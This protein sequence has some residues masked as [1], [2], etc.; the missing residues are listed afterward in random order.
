MMFPC[1]RNCVKVFTILLFFPG[2]VFTVYGDTEAVGDLTELGLES[3]MEIEITTVAK[4]PQPLS[5]AAA[6]IHVI[7]REEIRRSGATSI[8][9][10]LRLAPG[11]QVARVNGSAWA[12]SARGFNNIIADKL[13]VLIDGRTIYNPI[14]SGV[15]WGQQE[16]VL[17]DID[18]IEVIRGPG[19]TLWGANAVNG[20]INII[21]RPAAE[22]RGGLAVA[23]GGDPEGGFGTLRYGGTLG[24]AAH[25]RVY[26]QHVERGELD[27]V[28]GD[29]AGDDGEQTQVG[30][31]IDW[32]PTPGDQI[33][34]QGDAFTGKFGQRLFLASLTPPGMFNITDSGNKHGHNIML[35]WQRQQES[36]GGFTLQSYYDHYERDSLISGE[37]VGTWDIDFQHN[38]SLHER[39]DFLWG[40]GYRHQNVDLEERFNT[41]FDPSSRD[42]DTFSAFLQGDIHLGERWRLTLGSKFEHNDFTGF[43][44]QPSMRLL[45]TV[46]EN[47]S[48][49][50]AVSRAVRT[51]NLVND[52]SRT[53]SFVI[54]GVLP[55]VFES[56]GSSDFESEELIA[57]EAGYR[58][59]PRPDLALDVAVFYNDYDKLLSGEF[60]PVPV[61]QLIPV[62][63][64]LFRSTVGNGVFGE[65]YGAEASIDWQATERWRLTASYTLLEMALHRRATS[66]DIF[67][68]VGIEGSNPEQ[69]FQLRSYLDLPHNLEFDT[70]LYWVDQ[71]PALNVDDYL[72]LD[73]H[74][75][76]R[77]APGLQLDL[78][79]QSLLDD[80]HRETNQFLF[81]PSEVPRA[82]FG[83][84]SIAW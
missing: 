40:L 64:L 27:I 22:T 29:G 16:V 68:E 38:T 11:L 7:T 4:K 3:L 37:S 10:A 53:V 26:G 21:T 8:P 14:F 80:R 63:H 57:F 54:P 79:A 76:W 44:Y 12:I 73:L 56:S 31:R 33:T 81:I 18:R 41:S 2:L 32:Q 70:T 49:W 20:V 48:L 51:P 58:G 19:G 82:I 78:F 59:Q 46:T 15:H 23:G 28:S 34:L 50:G 61:F 60:N 9:E 74:L 13:L 65:T 55:L 45:W 30:G 67:T 69:Q 72:R 24:T 36:G 39:L 77:P 71:L 47:H 6:A 84:V 1:V 25:Y 35:R 75:G 83:R 52:Q 43:E 66:S 62:P 42:L 5:E 17:A